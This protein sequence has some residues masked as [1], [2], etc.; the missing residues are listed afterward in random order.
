MMTQIKCILNNKIHKYSAA[1][2]ANHLGLNRQI[3]IFPLPSIGKKKP[4]PR[5][6]SSIAH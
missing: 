1:A 6:G 3:P 5:S 2:W 4:D